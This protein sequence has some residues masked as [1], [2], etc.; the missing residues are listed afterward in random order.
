M[1]AELLSHM[2]R[3][4]NRRKTWIKATVEDV[5]SPYSVKEHSQTP[6]SERN[7]LL[8]TVVRSD[9]SY[10]RNKKWRFSIYDLSQAVTT[11]SLKDNHFFQRAKELRMTSSDIENV[12]LIVSTGII[13][14]NLYEDDY[15]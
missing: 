1:S 4:M 5:L 7:S 12:I 3:V 11:L 9:T 6:V 2:V 13:H 14:L 10:R 8:L 15:F